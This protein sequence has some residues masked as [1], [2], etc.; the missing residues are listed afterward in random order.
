MNERKDMTG[1]EKLQRNQAKLKKA[2]EL[3]PQQ[4]IPCGIFSQGWSYAYAGTTRKAVMHDPVQCAQAA[5]KYLDDFDV[6]YAAFADISI[7]VYQALGA[8]NYHWAPDDCAVVHAQADDRYAD[9][10]DYPAFISNPMGFLQEQMLKKRVPA[11][12]LPEDEAYEGLKDAAIEMK[13]QAYINQLV[14]GEFDRRGI[15]NVFHSQAPLFQG[16]FSAIFDYFRGIKGALVDIRRRPELVDAACDAYFAQFK[17]MH[18]I[19]S[20]PEDIRQQYAGQ[21]LTFGMSILN[22]E[23]FLSPRNFDKYYM[24]YFKACFEPYMEAGVKFIIVG[25]GKLAQVVD[26]YADLPKGSILFLLGSDDPYDIAPIMKGRQ[27]FC[28]GA[29]LDLLRMGTQEDCIAYAQ[30]CIDDF[31]PDGGFVFGHNSLL[32]AAGDGRPE[33]VKAVYDYV[34]SYNA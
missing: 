27:A 17:A 33:N 1:A 10:E 19:M 16:P 31:A 5:T 4:Q 7:E 25:E 34:A 15:I 26:R 3:V 12:Q 2:I 18:G 6:A 32:M 20:D 22:A 11:F 14:Q 8:T 30:K 29:T 21:T 13:K 24:R 9:P 23:C 28:A